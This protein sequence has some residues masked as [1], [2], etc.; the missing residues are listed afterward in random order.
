MKRFALFR[1]LGFG[2][3]AGGWQD[4]VDSYDSQAEAEQAGSDGTA[5]G[6][7]YQVVDLSTGQVVD[8]N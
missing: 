1:F 6:Q 4:F 7:C 5:E 8:E 3:A 2:L